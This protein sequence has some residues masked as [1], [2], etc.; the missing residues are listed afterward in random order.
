[1]SLVSAFCVQV[2]EFNSETGQ[3]KKLGQRGA[4][5]PGANT[6]P[7]PPSVFPITGFCAS[8]FPICLRQLEFPARSKHTVRF[9]AF[10][11]ISSENCS[12]MISGVGENKVIGVLQGVQC[13]ITHQIGK[14]GSS[15]KLISYSINN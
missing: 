15:L 10:D 13:F 3:F 2:V 11:A 7:Q 1:M 14:N 6:K 12:A 8:E 5:P 9:Q 4:A